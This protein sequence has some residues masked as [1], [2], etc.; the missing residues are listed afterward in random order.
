MYNDRYDLKAL[1]FFSLYCRNID[2][3]YLYKRH[4]DKAKITWVLLRK[5]NHEDDVPRA[6]GNISFILLIRIK[7][8]QELFLWFFFQEV[9]SS[10]KFKSSKITY[11][12]KNHCLY[13]FVYTFK[14]ENAL[15]FPFL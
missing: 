1:L 3:F 2:S 8:I 7:D 9:K 11:S 14:K 15:R 5:S 13:I 4:T 6:N 10:I 12:L